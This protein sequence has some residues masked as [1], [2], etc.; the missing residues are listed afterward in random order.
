MA[1][2]DN[3]SAGNT[4][5]PSGSASERLARLQTLE[6]GEAAKQRQMKWV[7]GANYGMMGADVGYGVYAAG[8]AAVASGAT[9]AAVAG[10][11]ALAAAPAVVALAGAWALGQIG[12][13]GAL[14]AG[15]TRVGDAL[16]LTIGR[17]DPHPACVGD[18]IAHSSGFLGMLGGLAAGVAIGAMVAATVATGGLAGALIV[19]ACMAGGLSIGGALAAASQSM[20]SNCGTITSG[21]PNV[22]FEGKPAARVTDV[23]SCSHHSDSP[24][25]LVEGSK[26]I[27]INGLPLVRI[28]HS[29]HCSAKVNAGRNSVWVDKTTGQYGPKNPELSAA[30][31]FLAGLLGGVLGAKLGGLMAKALPK[32]EPTQ[33][34]EVSGKKDEVSTCKEDPIDVATGE[35]VDL[36]TDVAIPG[37]LPLQLTRRY[38]TRA[39][40]VGLL[41]PRWSTSWSQRLEFADGHLVRFHTA[42]GQAISFIAPDVG[43][44]GINLREPRY[45]LLGKRDE[46]RIFDYE[47]RQVL[48]FSPL[49]EGGTSRL[50]RIEDLSGNSI[51]FA[52]DTVGRLTELAHTDGYRLK[53]RYHGPAN[54]VDKIDLIDEN[55]KLQTLVEYAYSNGMLARVE[56]FQHGYFRYTYDTN[57]WMTS[58]LDSDQTEVRYRYDDAGRVVQTETRQGYHTGYFVY[59][60]GC[61][62][63][64]DGDGEWRYEYNGDGLVTC[65]TDPLGHR[66]LREWQLGRLISQTDALGRRTTFE[67]DARGSLIAIEEPTGSKTRFEYDDNRLMTVVALANGAR[68]RFEYDHLQRLTARIAPDGS[69]TRYRYGQRGELLRVVDG[70]RETRLDYDE[71]LRLISTRWPTGAE[72]RTVYDVLGRLLEETAPDGGRAQYKYQAGANN[73]RGMVSEIT[74]AD[75]TTI[76]VRYNSEGLPVEHIDPLARVTRREYGPFDLVTASIDAAG[77]VTCFEYDHATRLTKVINALL[78]T[79]QYRY[80]GAGRLVEEIDWGGRVTRYERDAVGRLL[81]KTLPDGGQWRYE[82]DGF[83]RLASVDAGD[84]RLAYSYDELGRLASAEVQGESSHIT[85]FAY[86]AKGRLIGEDQHGHLL[87]H[88]YD[89]RGARTARITPHRE[90]KY[91]YDRLGALTK[92]GAMSILRDELGRDIGRQAGEFVLQRQ[93]D[94]MGRLQRQAA[95]PKLAFENMGRDSVRAFDSLAR[96]VYSYDPAGQLR[97]IDT[98]ADS[99][100]FKH[101]VRGQVTSV[102]SALGRAESYSYDANRNIAEH[103]HD[104]LGDTHRYLAGGLPERVGYARYKYDARGRTIEKTVEQPGFRP[105]TWHYSWDGLNRLVKVTTPDKGVWVYRYDA[106]NRRVEKRAVGGRAA[107]RFLWDGY[108]L[109]ERWEEKRDGTTGRTVTWHTSPSDYAPLAQETDDGF[110]PILA[111]QVG[112]PKAIFTQAGERVWSPAATVWGKILPAKGAANDATGSGAD[113]DTSLRFAGQWADEES[114]L[115][116]NLNRY[117]DA[118]TGQYLSRDPIGLAGGLRTQGYVSETTQWVDPLGLAECGSPQGRRNAPR[119]F[120]FDMVRNPGP[121]ADLRGN[122]AANF[123]GGKYNATTLDHD[124][125]LYRAGKAGGGKNGLGQWFT[126]DPILSEAQGRLDLAIKPQWTDANGALTGTSPLQSAYAVRIPKGTT[127]YEGPVGYQ[128]GPYLGGQDIMQIYVHQ[129]WTIPGVQVLSET[130]LV[131]SY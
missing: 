90:T 60:E 93:Y 53:L 33:S 94:V 48:V 112:M 71:Q 85:R 119:A 129:P 5:E 49:M 98:D 73:P 22:T 124:V 6:D 7:D 92:V 35:M 36:R 100:A 55:E 126:R 41:G 68:V 3:N 111:D 37:V 101:D 74:Q 99:I 131:G 104:V 38:R 115:S 116:Y 128:G 25:P 21:S 122:P 58:W 82:Y 107:V 114:G 61:T 125:T 102:R 62:R 108:V 130:P 11:A 65:E 70:D 76:R 14:A 118:E 29:T 88:V 43:L 96:Q 64:V 54:T 8:S 24:E 51:L 13:T 106:F 105:K 23:T 52:Y 67:Y 127:I 83:D 45:R 28:G 18:A 32:R 30:E 87:R 34:A 95:G 103:G 75:G 84:V 123:A 19:G 39:D 77:H 42:G 109:A 66:T 72:F 31:E 44:D 57:G 63:V 117:Y 26:T 86:D 15:A 20:G 97:H 59:E 56:S 40:D 4:G 2:Q 81:V 69:A 79:W 121:L 27:T 91:E 17:G 47:T 80:D 110:Y 10:A 46:P 120:E 16:G 89:A 78:E 1:D 50:E 113:F 9:G 12:V